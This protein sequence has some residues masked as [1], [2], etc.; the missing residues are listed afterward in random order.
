MARV[1]LDEIV[2]QATSPAMLVAG[3][4]V[5]VYERGTED[6][7]E[8]FGSEAGEDTLSQPLSTD[9][10]GR[11]EGAGKRPWL[12]EGS[13][14]VKVN[15]EIMPWE[16]VRGDLRLIASKGVVVGGTASTPRPVGFASV[17]WQQKDEPENALE[18]DTWIAT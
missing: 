18:G 14:D 2:L 17:E 4:E 8:V 9:D 10:D 11:I 7:A 5:Y 16:A 6:E 15:G 13:Y 1:A 3:A 12:E